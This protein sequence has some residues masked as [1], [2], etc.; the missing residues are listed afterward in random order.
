M[1][2][3]IAYVLCVLIGI[4]VYLT[5]QLGVFYLFLAGIGVTITL[6]M[7]REA[8]ETRRFLVTVIVLMALVRFF[9]SL[10]VMKSRGEELSQDEG[11]YS[12]KA[13]LMVYE[14]KYKSDLGA[15]FQGY[16]DDADMPQRQY[17]INLYT[18]VLA[19]F[20]KCFGYQIQAARLINIFVS[21]MVFLCVFYLTRPLFGAP[22]ARLASVFYA[23]FPSLTFWSVMV[24]I[25]YF[26]LL[27]ILL[28]LM[29]FIKFKEKISFGWVLVF[30]AACLVTFGVRY[31]IFMVIAVEFIGIVM[32]GLFLRFSAKM[33]IVL[34]GAGMVFVSV[35]G[36]S[37]VINRM[38]SEINDLGLKIVAQQAL[39]AKSDMAGYLIYP[40]HCYQKIS[41]SLGD[42]AHGYLKGMWYVFFSPFPWRIESPLQCM[43][44]PQTIIM[45]AMM[46][47]I[48]YGMALSFRRKIR[49]RWVLTLFVLSVATFLALIEGNI[50]ALFRHKDMMTP[51]LLIFFAY[52]LHEVLSKARLP[53]ART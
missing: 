6:I 51:V 42:L 43:A 31:H 3:S 24:G 40:I 9:L 47:F 4:A 45:Y 25:D 15:K 1:P 26:A 44:Y 22:T 8:R 23:F 32:A 13:L 14:Q 27:G 53:E 29:S 33:K 38:I 19:L 5:P 21:I 37:R 52:G 41:C 35:V 2:K 28:L 18:Y 17:G 20:Y 46:P 12:K 34:L 49:G 50:G 16:F 39:L 36:F 11:L 10:F 48:L 7:K 30:L